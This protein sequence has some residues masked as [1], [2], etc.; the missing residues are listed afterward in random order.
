MPTDA[1]CGLIMAWLIWH[2]VVVCYAVKKLHELI[3][4]NIVY[5]R[6]GCPSVSGLQQATVAIAFGYVDDVLLSFDVSTSRNAD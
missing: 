1:P 4:I 6:A 5:L 2:V 3:V